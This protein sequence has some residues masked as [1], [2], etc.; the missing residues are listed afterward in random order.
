MVESPSEN[1]QI[2]RGSSCFAF[3]SAYHRLRIFIGIDR[4]SSEAQLIVNKKFDKNS[5]LYDLIVDR[6]LEIMP[7]L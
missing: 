2:P 4:T 3:E 5:L 6:K 1:T 7:F